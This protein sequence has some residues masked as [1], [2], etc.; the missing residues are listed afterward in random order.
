MQDGGLELY[1]ELRSRQVDTTQI[2]TKEVLERETNKLWQTHT[3]CPGT[4]SHM[5]HNGILD[6]GSS[7]HKEV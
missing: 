2:F 1:E 7:C 4:M 5:V 6:D 3:H